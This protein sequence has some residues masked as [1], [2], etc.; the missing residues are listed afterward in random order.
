MIFNREPVAV[1]AA[2]EAIILAVIAF[3][4]LMTMEQLAATIF[5]V[6]AVLALIARRNVTPLG[7]DT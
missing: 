2:I 7:T 4:D 1:A 3:A 5:A 6:N